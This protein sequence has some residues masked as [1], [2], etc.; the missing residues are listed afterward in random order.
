MVSLGTESARLIKMEISVRKMG[1]IE[2]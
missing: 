1:E 2:H